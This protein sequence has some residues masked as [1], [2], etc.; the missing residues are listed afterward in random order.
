MSVQRSRRMAVK[1][2]LHPME[3]PERFYFLL[4]N[5]QNVNCPSDDDAKILMNTQ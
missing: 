2:E 1:L 5:D 3:G 4:L